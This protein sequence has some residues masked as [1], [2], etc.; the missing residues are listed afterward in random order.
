MAHT[1]KISTF[2]YVRRFQKRIIKSILLQYGIPEKIVSAFCVLYD[3]STFVDRT[4]RYH[5]RLTTR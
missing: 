5:Q 3:Q 1:L 4:I 2:Y